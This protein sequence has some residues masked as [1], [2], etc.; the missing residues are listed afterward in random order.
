MYAC[1]HPCNFII[2]LL[3]CTCVYACVCVCVCIIYARVRM[4]ICMCAQA[5]ACGYFGKVTCSLYGLRSTNLDHCFPLRGSFG[6]DSKS[7][8]CALYLAVDTF[9]MSRLTMIYGLCGVDTARVER[10]GI[11]LN[12]KRLLMQMSDNNSPS[13]SHQTII[14]LRIYV[15]AY[16][17][18]LNKCMFSRR[19]NCFIH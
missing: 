18:T 16:V 1:T 13:I 6:Y 9:Q 4:C 10:G 12:K 5:C 8:S 7:V 3:V 14:C 19:C 11:S 17:C 2:G 15:R